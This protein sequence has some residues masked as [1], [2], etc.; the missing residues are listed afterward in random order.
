[1]KWMIRQCKETV[2]DLSVQKS[3][4]SYKNERLLVM[5][6]L[7]RK[8]LIKVLILSYIFPFEIVLIDPLQAE[9]IFLFDD[10]SKKFNHFPCRRERQIKSANIILREGIVEIFS[11][12]T[13][14]S[15]I[16]L[17]LNIKVRTLK[18]IN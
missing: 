3:Q 7:K 9:F 4:I 17:Y 11:C 10:S 14:T 12:M 15:F 18:Q 13:R 5:N 6:V 16:I 1:M 8:I 2:V